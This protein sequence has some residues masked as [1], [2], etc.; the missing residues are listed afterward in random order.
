MCV[1]QCVSVGRSA[2]VPA[3]ALLI[4][5]FISC[6]AARAADRIVTVGLQQFV[7][8]GLVAVG[9]IPANQRDKFGET[10]GSG[11]GMSVDRSSWRRTATGYE[12][13]FVLLPDRGYNVDGTTNYRPRLNKLAIALTPDASTRGA[14]P[15][16]RQT[17]VKATLVDTLLLTDTAGETLTGLDPEAVRPA[18]AGLPP[19]P[20]AGNGHVSLDPEAV[21]WLHDG[22]YVISDEY[23][24]Y[25]YR[26]SAAC[27][28]LTAMR[29]PEAFIP[30]RKG[31][32]HFSS[33]NPRGGAPKPDP[34]H[35][36][37]GRQNNQGF[38]GMSLLPDGTHLVVVLDSATRQDG[39]DAS[40]T[41]RYTRMLRYDIRDAAQPHLEA[42]YVVPLPVFDNAGTTLRRGPE[43]A[44]S[45]QR[46]AIPAPR[47]RFQQRLRAEG[48]HVAVS[49]HHDCRHRRRYEHRRQRL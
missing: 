30:M 12:G 3:V 2:A 11:S 19:W 13:D 8:K 46:L 49:R 32:Q 29:P 48:R 45:A 40:S 24:P 37:T 15:E 38:E 33:N 14:P 10:F 26:F 34:L 47:P 21:V 42:E 41:R 18:G 28:M 17:G 43:R 4:A 36:D 31:V 39:G 23:G 20:L 7:D 25:I 16:R 9:R 1:R 6:S 44:G 5:A 27:T 35:P 22:G